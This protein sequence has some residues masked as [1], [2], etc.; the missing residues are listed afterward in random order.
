MHTIIHL[1]AL[2]FGFLML[3]KFLPGVKI[4]SPVTAVIAAVVF[5]LLN[6]A[7]GWLIGALL[8]VPAILTLG[9][10]L[11]FIPFIVNTV[12]LWLTDKFIADFEITDL[13]TL[14]ISSGAISLA[15]FLFHRL[16]A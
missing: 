8:V 5:S 2:T 10:L 14:L 11:F 3:A 7:L 12:I 15:N 6:W 1:G 16:F 4:K 13:P 9:L